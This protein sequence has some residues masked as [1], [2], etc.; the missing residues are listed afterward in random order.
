MNRWSFIVVIVDNWL[1]VWLR[2]YRPPGSEFVQVFVQRLAI[3]PLEAPRN[4]PAFLLLCPAF[5]PIRHNELAVFD[6]GWEI[7]RA[8]YG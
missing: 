6:P 8:A 7:G 3:F 4:G 2:F 1:I 5:S